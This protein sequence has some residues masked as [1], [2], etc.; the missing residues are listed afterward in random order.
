VLKILSK[1]VLKRKGRNRSNDLVDVITK[2]SQVSN[3]SSFVFVN[4]DRKY[5]VVLH[6]NEVVIRDVCSFGNSLGVKFY[7]DKANKF[8]VLSRDRKRKKEKV[9]EVGGEVSVEECGGWVK[10]RRGWR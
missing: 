4:N 9:E 3:S 5:Y 1:K 6:G 7:D 10:G 8:R 2:G